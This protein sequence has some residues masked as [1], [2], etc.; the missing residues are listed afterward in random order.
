MA[1]RIRSSRERISRS[2]FS[3]SWRRAVYSLLVLTSPSCPLYL[4]RLAS[5]SWTSSSSRFRSLAETV[6]RALGRVQGRAVGHDLGLDRRL[7]LGQGRKL[8][9]ETSQLHVGMVEIHKRLKIRMHRRSGSY[10]PRARV[11]STQISIVSPSSP[12]IDTISR[13]LRVRRRF[14]KPSAS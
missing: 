13:M 4:D 9:V 2:T 5:K 12:T 11:Y 6:E 14:Q 3:I 1:S 10:L 8:A 7:L